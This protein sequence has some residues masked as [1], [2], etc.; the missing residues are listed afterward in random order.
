MLESWEM[1]VRT[2]DDAALAIVIVFVCLFYFVKFVLCVFDYESLAAFCLYV[3]Y[4]CKGKIK[5]WS[6]IRLLIMPVGCCLGCSLGHAMPTSG[7]QWP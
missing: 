2:V 6:S 5:K 7:Q 3:G 4:W 1:R